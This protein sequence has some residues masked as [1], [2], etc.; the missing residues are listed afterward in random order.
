MKWRKIFGLCTSATGFIMSMMTMGGQV[1][2]EYIKV[3]FDSKHYTLRLNF[4]KITP[5]FL[6]LM[7][8]QDLS[9]QRHDHHYHH[10]T[11]TQK[12]LVIPPLKLQNQMNRKLIQVGCISVC[13]HIMYLIS[14]YFIIPTQMLHIS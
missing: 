12:S 6:P 9:R 7:L 3:K 10:H 8:R 4:I 14:K 13:L 11:S 1:S 5:A 2:E